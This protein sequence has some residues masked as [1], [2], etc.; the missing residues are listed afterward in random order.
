MWRHRE[1]EGLLKTTE[2]ARQEQLTPLNEPN[3]GEE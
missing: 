3:V 2:I 1:G